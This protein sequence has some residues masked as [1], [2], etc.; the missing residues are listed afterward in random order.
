MNQT[1]KLPRPVRPSNRSELAEA[2]QQ[3]VNV[4][5][6]LEGDERIGGEIR[7][8]RK[9]RDLTLAELGQLTELSQGYLSQIERGISNPSVKALYSIS[10]ALGVTVSWFFSPVSAGDNGLQDIVVRAN[11]RRHLKFN[12]GI[13]DELLSPNLRRKIELL[14]CIFP[15]G[16][17]SGSEPFSHQGEQAGIVISGQLRLWVDDREVVLEAGDSFAFENDKP[18]WYDNP[19]DEVTVVIWVITPPSY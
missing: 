18:H 15:P 3:S 13:T 1:K 11:Q 17:T 9:A 4:A 5:D 19:S 10:Q 12:S 6:L 7:D 2:G 14:R 8:L 16:T